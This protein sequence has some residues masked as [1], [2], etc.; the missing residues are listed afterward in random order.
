M[1]SAA[2]AALAA[3]M[4]VAAG[5]GGGP[6]VDDRREVPP[7]ER[8]AVSDSIDVDVTPGNGRQVTVH[9]GRDV[10]DRV[11]TESSDGVLRLDI[12]DRGIVIGPDP[13]GDVRVQVGADALA[14]VQVDGA[15][16]VTLSGIDAETLDL[17]IDGAGE[18]EAGGTVDRLTAKIDG[19]GDARLFGLASRTARVVVRS[20]G[21]AEVSVSETLDVEVTG[22]GDVQYRGT[23]SVRSDVSGAGDLR[24]AG[25]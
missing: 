17:E 19:A 3:A 4:V 8:I 7:F 10:L 11:S 6:R 20:A 16:N 25:S 2:V 15:S 5:C 12:V 24:S 21:N 18:L 9:A 14:G 22:A 23:P 13:L 1:R